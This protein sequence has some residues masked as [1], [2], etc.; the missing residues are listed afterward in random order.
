MIQQTSSAVGGKVSSE[1][2][3]VPCRREVWI[4]RSKVLFGSIS[5]REDASSVK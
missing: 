3:S 5:G 1:L 2:G 4:L